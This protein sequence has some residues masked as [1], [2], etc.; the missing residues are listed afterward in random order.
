MVGGVSQF[1]RLVGFAPGDLTVSCDMVSP[2]HR[3][4]GAKR[5][6]A[7]VLS[8]EAN[9]SLGRAIPLAARFPQENAPFQGGP[10][11]SLLAMAVMTKS[12]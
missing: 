3:A 9:R 6:A 8:A 5:K 7:T 12:W 11:C 4:T 2:Q 1:C 10:A